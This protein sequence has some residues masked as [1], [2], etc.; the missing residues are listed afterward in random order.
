MLCVRVVLNWHRNVC[1]AIIY[2]FALNE[3][4]DKSSLLHYS[5]F[6]YIV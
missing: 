5:L 4:M 6:R 2:A 3:A 1:P